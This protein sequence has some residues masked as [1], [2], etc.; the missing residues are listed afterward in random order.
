[1]SDRIVIIVEDRV[2]Q[3]ISNIPC[4]VVLEVHDYD[5]NEDVEGFEPNSVR[6][7]VDE[8]GNR[9]W[10]SLWG[11]VPGVPEREIHDIATC[12][13]SRLALVI[14]TPDS[15]YEINSFACSRIVNSK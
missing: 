13:V 8:D 12:D 4:G 3:E 5:C 1:M 2:L 10:L 9:Y 6:V 11:I 15:A 7:G 14:Q